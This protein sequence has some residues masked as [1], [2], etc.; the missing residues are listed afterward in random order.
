MPYE[1]HD[2]P[3][4][5]KRN[6]ITEE[7]AHLSHYGAL[8]FTSGVVHRYNLTDWQTCRLYWDRTR[9]FLGVQCVQRIP[10]KPDEG[11]N[12]EEL[13]DEEQNK[14]DERESPGSA[15]VRRIYTT[16]NSAHLMVTSLLRAYAIEAAADV[17]CPVI[18]ELMPDGTQLIAV[19]L[20]PAIEAARRTTTQT[21]RRGNV[22]RIPGKK[23]PDGTR[24]VIQVAETGLPGG[25]LMT[26]LALA[27][28]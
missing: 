12:G 22:R 21:P 18:Q 5:R 20:T 4:K 24:P 2:P 13:A 15:G 17:A 7:T 1:Q 8:L 19:D 26:S 16:T 23:R 28:A 11:E 10:E 9:N 3:H 25:I 14:E 27:S 6:D